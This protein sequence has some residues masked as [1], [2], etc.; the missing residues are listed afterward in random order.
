ME[1][2]DSHEHPKFI[3]AARIYQVIISK[4]SQ[5]Y[6]Y[7]IQIKYCHIDAGNKL[8]VHLLLLSDGT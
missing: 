3:M 5:I 6:S 8:L 4:V 7:D 2:V 1:S